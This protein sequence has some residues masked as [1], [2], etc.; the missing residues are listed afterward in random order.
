MAEVEADAVIMSKAREAKRTAVP[1][2]PS[3]LVVP[4]PP[5]LAAAE[6]EAAHVV[7]LLQAA[8]RQLHDSPK[9]KEGWLVPAVVTRGTD[10]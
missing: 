5:P 3:A 4:P 6:P 9:Q 10:G 8:A 7:E 1:P 2:V